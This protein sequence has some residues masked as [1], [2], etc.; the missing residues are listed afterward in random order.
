MKK[1]KY[2]LWVIFFA[3]IGLLVIQNK[4]VFLAKYSLSLNL[5]VYEN[6]TPEIFNLVVIA[7]FFFCGILIAY[8]AS[9]L[10]RYRAKKTIKMLQATID[11]SSKTIDDLKKEI[12][13][14]KVGWEPEED[15]E[16]LADGAAQTQ[17]TEETQPS[18]V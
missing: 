6:R 2:G 16:T 15:P 4:D 3:L 14:L 11:G 10:E 1:L 13:T 12:D 18:Q 9:L 5:G 8:T 7:V 17:E